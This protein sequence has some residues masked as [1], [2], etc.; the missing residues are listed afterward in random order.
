MVRWSLGRMKDHVFN[1]SLVAI[2]DLGTNPKDPMIQ[3]SLRESSVLD[4]RW[5]WYWPLVKYTYPMGVKCKFAEIEST[6]DFKLV[7]YT[8]KFGFAMALPIIDLPVLWWHSFAKINMPFFPCLFYC[9]YTFASELRN[10]DSIQSNIRGNRLDAEL[11]YAFP[12][13]KDKDFSIKW[14]AFYNF[15]NQTFANMV[16][17]DIKFYFNQDR[18][19]GFIVGYQKGALPPEFKN[20]EAVKTGF[21]CNF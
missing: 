5:H 15:E 17:T 13:W 14:W 7:D 8:F 18:K 1:I 12:I 10:I 16:D 9:G 6:Q 4:Y 3:S 11:I 21:T 2:G 19:A 20:S